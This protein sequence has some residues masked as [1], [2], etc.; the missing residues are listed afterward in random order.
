MDIVKDF[1]STDYE[2]RGKHGQMVKKLT[3][4]LD[5]EKMQKIKIF[6]TNINVMVNAPMIGFIFKEK[7][8]QR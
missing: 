3:G 6:D 5:E 2:I 1:Y 4:T 8:Y 7:A